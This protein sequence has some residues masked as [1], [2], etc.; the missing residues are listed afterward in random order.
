MLAS[1]YF[2]FLGPTFTSLPYYYIIKVG[3]PWVAKYTV[4]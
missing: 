4:H 2:P 1:H 3:K